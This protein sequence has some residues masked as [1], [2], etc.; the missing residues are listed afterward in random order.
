MTLS[1]FTS[2]SEPK[3]KNYEIIWKIVSININTE[4]DLT[5]YNSIFLLKTQNK[6]TELQ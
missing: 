3:S 6:H 1:D 5:Q 4:I 2:E